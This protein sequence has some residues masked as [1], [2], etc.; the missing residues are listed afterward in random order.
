MPSFNHPSRGTLLLF[1]FIAYAYFLFSERKGSKTSVP[2][3][4]RSY[5]IKFAIALMILMVELVDYS[6]G[7]QYL[8]NIALG[9]VY[10]VAIYGVLRFLNTHIDSVVRK[11]TIMTIEAKRYS[12]YWLLYLSLAELLFFIVYSNLDQFA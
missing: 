8:V 1:F 9:L 5:L 11:S 7:Q 12:F 10:F 3:S 2:V 6:L 4:L